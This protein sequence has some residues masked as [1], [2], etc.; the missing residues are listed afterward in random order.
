MMMVATAAFDPQSTSAVPHC[1]AVAV[2]AS[3]LSASEAASR[4]LH[5]VDAVSAASWA[6]IP[7]TLASGPGRWDSMRRSG[8][9]WSTTVAPSYLTRIGSSQRVIAFTHTGKK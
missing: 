2:T 5:D 1:A 9:E 8:T 6:G 4:R 3:T 7:Q